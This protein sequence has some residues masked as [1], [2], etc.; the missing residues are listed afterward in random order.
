MNE[1][2][3]QSDIVTWFSQ[4]HPKDRGCL[5]A[6]NNNSTSGRSGMKNKSLGVHAGVSDLI[7]WKDGWMVGCEIKSNDKEHNK[8]HILNQI[9]WGETVEKNGGLYFVFTSLKEFKNFVDDNVFPKYTLKEIKG[10]VD[11]SKSKVKFI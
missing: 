2:K 7:Y 11:K 8:S 5:F 6:I 1:N 10:L 3:I 9:E 4:Y